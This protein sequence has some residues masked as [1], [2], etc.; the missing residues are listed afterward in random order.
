MVNLKNGGKPGVGGDAWF[1]K[2]VPGR[3]ESTAVTTLRPPIK[4]P[5][6]LADD[7]PGSVNRRWKV[8]DRYCFLAGSRQSFSDW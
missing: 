7:L 4:S 6:L 8:R 2:A 3:L 5:S 1:E